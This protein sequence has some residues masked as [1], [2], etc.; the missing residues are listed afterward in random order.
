MPRINLKPNFI[1]NPPKPENKPKI[2]YF[3]TQLSGFILEL[4]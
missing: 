2:N 1:A 3:D 4:K